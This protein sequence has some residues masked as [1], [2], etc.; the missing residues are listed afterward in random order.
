MEDQ[1]ATP[2]DNASALRQWAESFVSHGDSKTLPPGSPHQQ[3]KEMEQLQNFM[4]FFELANTSGDGKL[5]LLQF[6]KG[7]Q[8]LRKTPLGSCMD[9][10]AFEIVHHLALSTF[11]KLD[12]NK[13]GVLTQDEIRF[14]IRNK[15]EEES[16]APRPRKLST[17]EMEIHDKRAKSPFSEY[18]KI[19][20]TD[21]NLNKE[22]PH[23]SDLDELRSASIELTDAFSRVV[24]A[25]GGSSSGSAKASDDKDEKDGEGEN[26][27]AEI[28]NESE[29]NQGHTEDAENLEVAEN[30]SSS[31]ASISPTQVRS[32]IN[33]IGNG[34]QR[35]KDLELIEQALSYFESQQAYFKSVADQNVHLKA[36]LHSLAHAKGIP[37]VRVT[38]P[39]VEPPAS[40]LTKRKEQT[41][42]ILALKLDLEAAEAEIVDLRQRASYYES[43]F[44]L[45]LQK[46]A[47]AQKKDKYQPESQ[48]SRRV[49]SPGE[50]YRPL[51]PKEAHTQKQRK[52]PESRRKERSSVRRG[53]YFGSFHSNSEDVDSPT[54]RMLN[55]LGRE[56]ERIKEYRQ[57]HLE[58][59]Y[60][61]HLQRM[62]HD[63]NLEQKG[64]DIPRQNQRGGK[65]SPVRLKEVVRVDNTIDPELLELSKGSGRN[66]L[67]ERRHTSKSPTDIRKAA[68]SRL[69]SVGAT[70]VDPYYLKLSQ[71]NQ[72]DY[73]RVRG[74]FGEKLN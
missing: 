40:N 60:N 6:T 4:R 17:V 25:K 26:V 57:K 12:V 5:S 53:T 63:H 36:S 68:A 67:A 62:L 50:T 45:S 35:S 71:G 18:L 39:E 44:N 64:I 49:K 34:S 28:T 24:S 3:E 22:S 11:R 42:L 16:R 23:Q 31:A 20:M 37:P 32:A 30:G 69:A 48:D 59:H 51:L 41:D 21:R 1:T 15:I 9:G 61:L 13:N 43:M 73:V 10:K 72:R 33:E 58:D 66:Y 19:M 52:S 7:L 56:R 8:V 70:S 14:Y 38:I 2:P 65:R 55:R 74:Q 47:R 29:N 54:K 27:K 46:D